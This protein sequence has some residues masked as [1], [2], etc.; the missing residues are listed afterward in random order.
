MPSVSYRLYCLDADG[1]LRDA[2]WFVAASDEGAVAK[3]EAKHPNAR[4]E[5]WHDRRLVATVSPVRR[6]A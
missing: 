2:E 5:I 1:R 6:S 4:S 3:V